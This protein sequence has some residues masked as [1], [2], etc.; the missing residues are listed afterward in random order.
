MSRALLINAILLLFYSV[1]SA[2]GLTL[3]RVGVR[4]EDLVLPRF[5]KA[6]T[7]FRVLLGFSILVVSFLTWIVISSRLPL[8]VAYPVAVGCIAI[9]TA[10]SSV[11]FDSAQLSFRAL[12]GMVLVVG[13]LTLLTTSLKT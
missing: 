8:W 9:L 13:G 3:I 1:L 2:A 6:I 11:M 10:T 4:G 5:L 7:D 12:L